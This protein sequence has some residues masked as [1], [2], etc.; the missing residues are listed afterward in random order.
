MAW[1]NLK[2]SSFIRVISSVKTGVAI[3]AAAVGVGALISAA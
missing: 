3:S 1:L 2:L